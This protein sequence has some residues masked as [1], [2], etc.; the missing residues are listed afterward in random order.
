MNTAELVVEIR[1]VVKVLFQ[2][3][4]VFIA[5]RISYIRRYVRILRD[6]SWNVLI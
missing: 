5:V 1:P 3:L 6:R 4:V 2:L